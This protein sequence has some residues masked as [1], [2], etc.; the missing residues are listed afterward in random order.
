[1][2]QPLTSYPT[3]K[4][5]PEG[6]YNNHS[7]AY[8][9]GNPSKVVRIGNGDKI[10]Y[11]SNDKGSSWTGCTSNKGASGR[12]AISA[13]GAT[14]LHCPWGSST[15]YYTT[16]NG[17]SWTSC[18]G[19]SLG[20]AIPAADQVNSNY[21][22]IYNP[23]NGQM[24]RS[25]NK[26]AS[27]S[28]AGT[29][30]G[31]TA[32]HPWEPTLIRTV[33][34]NEGHIWVPLKNNGLKYSTDHGATY[35]N[36]LNVPYC[37]TVGIGKP[38]VGASYPTIFIWGTVSGVTGL[39][40]STDQGATW[41]RLNDDEHEF[42]GASFL[43]GDMNVAGRV[44][45]STG[46]GRGIIY[47]DDLNAEQD[48]VPVTG[49]Q[50]GDVQDSELYPNPTTSLV[51]VPNARN[52]ARVTIRDIHGRHMQSI[53]DVGDSGN[54]SLDNL[55]AGVYLIQLVDKQNATTTKRLVKK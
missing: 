54:I 19:V 15:T 38:M 25:S 29:P 43:I 35:T 50:E 26:G 47:W 10:V 52:V 53:Y 45:M 40:R 46:G 5:S 3:K 34:N 17:A 7:I 24:L 8:A 37:K 13:D 4:L 42:A 28:V 18:S 49:I 6:G 32:F 21:F 11:Y 41:L 20:D 1:V 39:F 44:Y 30:G 22:Y 48:P 9:A 23:N 55:P 12:V 33:P 14:I 16:N 27:F 31:T 2:H 36:V 51:T